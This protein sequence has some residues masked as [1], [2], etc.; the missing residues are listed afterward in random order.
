MLTHKPCATLAGMRTR[1]AVPILMAAICIGLVAASCSSN[2]TVPFEGVG[3]GAG[4][5][6][7]VDASAGTAGTAG[8]SGDGG[9]AGASG[10]A[11]A[12]GSSG[13]GGAAGGSAGSGGAA[14][15]AGSSGT[16]GA[17]GTGGVAGAAGATGGSAGVGGSSGKGGSAGSAGTSGGGAGGASGAAGASGTAGQGGT[18]GIAGAGGSAGSSGASGSAGAA[19]A[20]SCSTIVRHDDASDAAYASEWSDATNG[21]VGFNAWQINRSIQDSQMD[22]SFL[23]TSAN[24]GPGTAS[25]N[26]DTAGKAFGLYANGNNGVSNAY[27]VAW[28]PFAT[29]PLAVGDTLVVRLDTGYVEPPDGMVGM[30]LPGEVP[31]FGNMFSAMPGT[32]TRFAFVFRGGKFNYES[33]DQAAYH[34]TSV[35]LTYG[36]LK[37]ALTLTAADAYSLRINDGAPL[38]GTLGGAAGT[39]ILGVAFFNYLAGAGSSHDL[40]F[41]SIQVCHP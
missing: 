33:H 27:V 13:A 26:I 38:T 29:S 19:G 17:A 32:T 31:D 41:N 3:G 36:G 35:A 20:G 1:H 34:D 4:K 15:T 11:G 16:A 6:A 2:D 22:G 21:G 7:G 12:G 39:P 9:V 30:A 14:G 28:R 10:S 25:T 18:A 8:V 40:F 37:L 5:E 23:G 24:N